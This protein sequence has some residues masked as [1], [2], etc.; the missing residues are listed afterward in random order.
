M[1]AC[2][3]RS[4]P[5]P[6][7]LLTL[8]CGAARGQTE[9][10]EDAY[11]EAVEAFNRSDFAQAVEGFKRAHRSLGEDH[12]LAAISLFSIG[13]S[14]ERLVVESP[15]GGGALACEATAW[16]TQ[17]LDRADP[18]D[19]R[20]D[21]LRT[22]ARANREAMEASCRGA[23]AGPASVGAAGADDPDAA[24]RRWAVDANQPGPAP[25]RSQVWPWM[26][27][28]AGGVAVAA[29]VAFALAS[30]DD[31]D[32][33]DDDARVRDAWLSV[34]AYVVGGGLAVGGAAWMLWPTAEPVGH[35]GLGAGL[36]FGWTL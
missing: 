6:L 3:A 21:A 34:A 5:L 12:R 2:C 20:L 27:I 23:G 16:Y 35:G 11:Y 15:A 13:K 30:Q 25:L 26:M 8:L 28:G 36:S 1:R 9:A 18:K 14:I 29:G 10:G 7:A 31:R 4:L 17:F 33:R 32:A 24:R 22:E 19:A